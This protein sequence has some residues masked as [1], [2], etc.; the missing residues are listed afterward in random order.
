MFDDTVFAY[1]PDKTMDGYFRCLTF[2][3]YG[4]VGN[5]SI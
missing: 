1:E 4:K 2:M 3:Y 5:A